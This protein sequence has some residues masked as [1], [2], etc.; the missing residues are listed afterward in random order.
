MGRQPASFTL[1]LEVC[2]LEPDQVS[3]KLPRLRRPKG[4]TMID[5]G[6]W[7]S[8]FSRNA[9]DWIPWLGSAASA[10]TGFV[11]KLLKA[12][13]DRSSSYEV[14]GHP[15]QLSVLKQPRFPSGPARLRPM[16]QGTAANRQTIQLQS[17]GSLP[18]RVT[19]LVPRAVKAV[20]LQS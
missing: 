8:S 13:R 17:Q 20:S 10:M 18:R 3:L 9:A 4:C 1:K 7:I 14:T 6:R 19:M 5:Q 11:M 2:W 16:S 15:A 12:A